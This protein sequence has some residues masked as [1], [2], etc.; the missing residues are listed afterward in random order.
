[1]DRT[2]ARNRSAGRDR[3]AVAIDGRLGRGDNAR[4]AVE[5][6]IVVRSEIDVRAVADQ[7]FRAGDPIMDAEER[8][9]DPEIIRR[10]LDHADFPVRFQVRDVEPGGI[11][12]GG[13]YYSRR[14]HPRRGG[15]GQLLYQPGLGLRGQSE[16]IATDCHAITPPRPS[17]PR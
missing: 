9:V 8:I 15:R 14:R 17:G 4:V 11:A 12:P 7:G 1:M 13:R 2:L 5:A 16:E 3:G 10:L 6:D